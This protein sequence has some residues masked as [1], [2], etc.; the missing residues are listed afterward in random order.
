MYSSGMDSRKWKRGG[1]FGSLRARS[2]PGFP[3]KVPRARFRTL[4]VE[5]FRGVP[6][7]RLPSFRRRLK[8]AEFGP[9]GPP[10]IAPYLPVITGILGVLK[11]ILEFYKK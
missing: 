9:P 5:V 4:L 2:E 11:V 6:M 3:A 8:P 10:K 1:C 7:R